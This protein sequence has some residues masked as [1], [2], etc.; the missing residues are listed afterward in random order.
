MFFKAKPHRQTCFGLDVTL[1][2]VMPAQQVR[3]HFG[4]KPLNIVLELAEVWFRERPDAGITF[5]DPLAAAAIF[6][7]ELCTYVSGEI[8]I[9]GD[10]DPMWCGRTF[11][12]NEGK[13]NAIHRVAKTVDAEAFFR[14]Y[15]GVFSE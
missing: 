9:A 7:P 10:P 1:Q 13:V 4:A 14:E 5:H 2:C 12:S 15:F 11:L 3:E 6:K 8:E